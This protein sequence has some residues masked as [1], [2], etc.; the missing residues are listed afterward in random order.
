MAVRAAMSL[1]DADRRKCAPR[2]VWRLEVLCRCWTARPCQSKTFLVEDFLP[3]RIDFTLDLAAPEIRLGDA[4]DLTLAAKYL[5]GAPGADLA[6]EGE[7]LLR[8]ATELEALQA[9][10]L[11]AM[12]SPSMR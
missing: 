7:V 11:A 12:T 2:G 9:M 8:A 5:F 4:P 1:P 3:E 6:I 10:S